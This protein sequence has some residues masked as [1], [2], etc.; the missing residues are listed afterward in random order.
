MEDFY[1]YGSNDELSGNCCCSVCMSMEWDGTSV[2]NQLILDDDQLADLK[3]MFV[4]RYFAIKHAKRT[5]RRW[6]KGP[7]TFCRRAEI[8]VY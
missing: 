7:G 3:R 6:I 5:L 4:K 2:E 8:T 1:I